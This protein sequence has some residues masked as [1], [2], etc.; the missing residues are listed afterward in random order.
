MHIVSKFQIFFH[1]FT[2][3]KPKNKNLNFKNGEIGINP[4]RPLTVYRTT[5]RSTV[6]FWNTVLVRSE[7][8]TNR[9]NRFN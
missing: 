1:I 9:N 2:V 3:V 8:E 4:S 5:R 7:E 6:K